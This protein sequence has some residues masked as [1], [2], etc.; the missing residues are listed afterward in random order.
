MVAEDGYNGILADDDLPA[1]RL[2][3]R[4]AFNETIGLCKDTQNGFAVQAYTLRFASSFS[5]AYRAF[6][7]QKLAGIVSDLFMTTRRDV[8]LATL[9]DIFSHLKLL[10]PEQLECALRAMSEQRE[11]LE[12][13]IREAVERRVI[14]A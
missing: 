10:S 9:T 2:T 13:R 14:A 3:I 11:S 8:S 6:K 1:L 12:S 5:T 7:E 4:D